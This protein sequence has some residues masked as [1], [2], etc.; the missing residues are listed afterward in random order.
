MA[1]DILNPRPGTPSAIDR[2]VQYSDSEPEDEA[3]VS[4][5]LL[6]LPQAQVP[7]PPA[8]QLHPQPEELRTLHFT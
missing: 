2:H 6:T 5:S 4:P 7:E 1:K 3:R 8:E